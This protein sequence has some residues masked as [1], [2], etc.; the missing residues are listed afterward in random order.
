V[1]LVLHLGAKVRE[2]PGVPIQDP[3]GLLKWL[4]KDRAI[5]TFTGLDDIQNRESSLKNIIVQWIEFV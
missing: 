3:H 2:I 1:G 5:I 4:A